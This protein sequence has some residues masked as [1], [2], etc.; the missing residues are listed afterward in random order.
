LKT[1]LLAAA[2]AV[3]CASC[4]HYE[5]EPLDPVAEHDALA[6]RGP[7]RE[8]PETA[9]ALPSE[10]FP[11]A[12]EVAV[13]DGLTQA[14]ANAL[15]LFHSPS[16]VA[17]RGELRLKGAELLRSGLLPNPE[18]FLGPRLA[19]EGSALIFPGS[20]SVEIPLAGHLDAEKGRAAAELEAA[21]FQ[22]L[23]REAEVLVSVRRRFVRIAGLTARREILTAMAHTSEAALSRTVDLV[24]A[25][26]A[27]RVALGLASLH[28]DEAG[29]DLRDT[30]IAL[31]RSQI[32]LLTFIGLLPNSSIEVHASRELLAPVAVPQAGDRS[33][34]L[35]HA[36]LR[37][38]EASY[39]ARE[40][41]LEGEVARQY[42]SLRVGPD[43]ESDDGQASIGLGLSISLPI[44]DSNAGGIAVATEHRAMRRAA[45]RAALVDLAARESLARMNLHAASA[46]L[47]VLR[48]RTLPAAES[49]ERALEARLR[50]GQTT[51]VE[52]LATRGAIARARL[53]DVEL[54]QEI[55]IRSLEALWYSGL[56]LAPPG[57]SGSDGRKER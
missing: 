38:L 13:D 8:Q 25:G 57:D 30:E 49:A 7:T 3:A 43:F 16:L 31:A 4:A 23:N 41:G 20:L 9:G 52:V 48:A 39:K 46:L 45:W 50:I 28:R 21:R 1:N 36:R 26:E 17:A 32:E 34:M 14:E 10:L 42:P 35:G 33:P 55:A 37:A 54:T 22:L 47:D 27:D 2:L 18:L 19:T 53:R 11:I 6:A 24:R 40:H 5:P 12:A 29:R 51:L 15:A 56:L 44:F